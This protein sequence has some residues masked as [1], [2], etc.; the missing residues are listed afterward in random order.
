MVEM[1]GLT[2]D[3]ILL[4]GATNRP[5]EIDEAARRRFRKKLL[6]ASLMP[7][8]IPLPDPHARRSLIDNIL[9][10]QNHNLTETD[11]NDIV[12][13]TC[14]Y[15]GSDLDNLVREA[16]L[17]PMRDVRDMLNA[18]VD[19]VRPITVKDFIQALNQV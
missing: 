10:S 11:L 13:K 4:I 1:T 17:G 14:D 5:G 2:Q 8:Y 16:A 9:S 7:R 3:K 12:D 15:S 18:S 6:S 19:D